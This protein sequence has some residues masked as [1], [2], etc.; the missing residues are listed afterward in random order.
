MIRS[1]ELGSAQ[2]G[3]KGEL[4][5]CIKKVYCAASRGEWNSADSL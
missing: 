1:K 2:V 3:V 5:L 4:R